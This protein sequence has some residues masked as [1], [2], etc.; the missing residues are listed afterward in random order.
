MFRSLTDFCKNVLLE[1]FLSFHICLCIFRIS[2]ATF[3][4][5]FTATFFLGLAKLLL[6]YLWVFFPVKNN[7]FLP[8]TFP[9]F[10]SKYLSSSEIT[11]QDF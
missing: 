2:Q 10:L 4:F 6:F 3:L 8:E 5:P 9:S 1:E 11:K 7:N